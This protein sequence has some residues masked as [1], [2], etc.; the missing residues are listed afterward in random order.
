MGNSKVIEVV[1]LV[2]QW[3]LSVY[4]LRFNMKR[5]I[6]CIIR[7]EIRSGLSVLRLMRCGTRVEPSII[8]VIGN[9]AVLEGRSWE[10]RCRGALENPIWQGEIVVQV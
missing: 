4:I 8:V 6:V 3:A 5:G 1:E 10:Y 9:G 2:A 7:L